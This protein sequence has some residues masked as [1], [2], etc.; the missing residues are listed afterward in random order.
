MVLHMDQIHFLVQLKDCDMPVVTFQRIE[1]NVLPNIDPYE[2]AQIRSIYLKCVRQLLLDN[3]TPIWATIG[4]PKPGPMCHSRWLTM[5]NRILRLY[6][7]KENPDRHL[8]TLINYIVK[9]YA[10]IFFEIKSKCHVQ[11]EV[12]ISFI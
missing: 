7:S 4:R 6:I 3:A 10:P 11:M 12:I 1:G 9:V 8:V 5:A 2:L